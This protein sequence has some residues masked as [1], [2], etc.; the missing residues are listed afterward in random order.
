[1][2]GPKLQIDLD[3]IVANWRMFSQR[4]APAQAAAVVKADAYGLGAERVARALTK[5]GCSR[6]YV[7]WP[8][9][10]EVARRAVGA[11]PEIFVFHGPPTDTLAVFKAHGLTPVLNSLQQIELWLGHDASA[12]AAVHVDVGMN[13]LGV[14]ESQWAE[15]A[16]MLPKPVRL[17]GHLACGDE[18]SALNAV[19]LE[20]FERAA[21]LW[22]GVACS[23]SATGGIYQGQSYHFD[24]VRPGIGLYGGG[25]A[26]RTV[27]TLTAPVLQVRDIR[28]GETVG[29]SASWA[30]QND[31][32]LATV[33]LGYADG[34]LRS[35]SNR[36]LGF[37][38]GQKRP[39]VGRV[40]MDLI[41]VD[42]TGLS[43]SVG[44]DIEFLGPNMPLAEVAGTMGTIDYEI[45]TRLGSRL[46]RRYVGGE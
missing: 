6:F 7:A 46:T 18:E 30:A 25:P 14:S 11:G 20:R 45:L 43:V 37:V 16:R 17:V 41:V 13:R 3:A 26:S 2:A 4:V 42:V 44:D 15:A 1:M 5:V 28:R 9:E 22:P 40:S 36:G 27:V 34:F 31:A 29:Y 21:K 8:Q 19:Q 39:I 35:A 10:G 12:P 33:G 32:T 38:A 24:E 23:L